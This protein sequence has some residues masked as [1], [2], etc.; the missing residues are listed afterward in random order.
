MAGQTTISPHHV[1][2]LLGSISWL[3]L[4]LAAWPAAAQQVAGEQVAQAARPPLVLDPVT[5]TATKTERSVDEVPANVTVIDA[6]KIE[7]RG[8]SKMEDIF[9]D[10]PG[11]EMVGGPRRLGQDINIRGFGGQRVV[12]TLDGARQ[13]FDAGHKGRFFLDP[14]LL[15]QVEVVRGSNS[16]LH[17]SGAI[18][19]V[20]SMETKNAADFLDSGETVGFRT[21]YGYSS[22][23]R[24]NYYSAGAFGRVGEKID[25]L[26]NFSFRDSGTLRQGGDK[27]LDYSAELLRDFFLKA[28]IRPGEHNKLSLSAI[29]FNENGLYPTNPD[30]SPTFTANGSNPLVDRDTMMTTL[31]ANYSYSNP[32]MPLLNPTVKIYRNDL[33]VDERR[34]VTA[35][36]TARRDETYLTTDGFDVYN[37][38]HFGTG[39]I[40]HA[41][42]AGIDFYK[43]EQEGLR[44]GAARS[45]FPTAEGQ[46]T[47]YYL[48]DEVALLPN[49]TLTPTL[50]YD[51]YQRESATIRDFEET[52]LSPKLAANWQALDWLGV[53]GSYGKAFRAPGMTEA[54]VAGQH[55]PSNNFV[56]NPNLRP[57][58]TKTAEGGLRLKFDNVA[59][60]GDR[61][62]F[63]TTYFHTEAKDLIELIVGSTTSTYTNTTDATIKGFES[64]AQYDTKYAF[65][66][67]GLS[68]IRGEN[69]VTGRPLDSIP[70]DKV[71]GVIGGKLPEYGLRFGWRSE[72]V[73][74]QDKVSGVNNTGGVEATTQMTSG[75]AV[76]GVFVTWLPFQEWLD[77]F[78]VDAGI[79]NIFDQSYRRHLSNIYDEGRDFRVAVS[80]T[81]GF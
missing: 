13:N 4:C 10:L 73:A 81:K 17:G 42:T 39:S 18:G 2:R 9:R 51:D 1:T 28:T 77:G 20:V 78:R 48:Q 71:V 75:Y 44:N 37:T 34:R 79:E 8:V 29:R 69:N 49:L 33:D 68:R 61:L 60:A 7:S 63:N 36:T 72:F 45:T 12:T 62:K 55:F 38:A 19:G 66:S 43:D 22:V 64:D 24:E 59:M 31:A 54:F 80:Y 46:V 50:R 5:I 74:E 6:E 27:E 23:A 52:A 47:G 65:G 3:A 14:D 15:R 21:K 58:K 16:A 56:S 67:I 30:S 76:H 32:D 70:A 11:V 41:I 53:Y 26:G 35:T 57:E 40:N 25:M